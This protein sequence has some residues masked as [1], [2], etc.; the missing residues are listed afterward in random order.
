MQTTSVG[1][2]LKFTSA[3]RTDKLEGVAGP[4]RLRYR[5]NRQAAAER[6]FLAVRETK[7]SYAQNQK[8]EN[9]K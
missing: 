7:T 1:S 4:R 9:G 3:T 2:D 8:E 5:N 6:Q